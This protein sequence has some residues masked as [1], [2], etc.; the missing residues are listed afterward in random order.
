MFGNPVILFILATW[1]RCNVVC[2][3]GCECLIMLDVSLLLY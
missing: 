3:C 1:Q 2:S